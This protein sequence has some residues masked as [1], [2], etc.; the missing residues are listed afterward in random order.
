MMF[1]KRFKSAQSA[2][3]LFNQANEHWQQRQF[4]ITAGNEEGA[5]EACIEVVRLCQ[6]SLKSDGN[7]G[8]AYVM[9]ANALAVAASDALGQSDRERYDNLQSMAAA[10][11]HYWYTLPHRGYPITKKSGLEIGERLWEIIIDELSKDKSLPREDTILLV[12]AYR[13][14]MASELISPE[15]F[16]E[17]RAII[18]NIPS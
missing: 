6:L 9:L 12:E 5:R 10:V 7:M 14:S 18:L 4:F 8:D 17:I 2:G 15:S 1:W 13:D 16:E 3:K 11:I